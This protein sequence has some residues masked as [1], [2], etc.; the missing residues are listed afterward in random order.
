MTR[1]TT[2]TR[3]RTPRTN[4]GERVSRT[5]ES[6]AADR[7]ERVAALQ[8]QILTATAALVEAGAWQRMLAVA[9]RFHTYSLGNQLLIALQDPD[10]T[11]IAGPDH[12][13]ARRLERQRVDHLALRRPDRDDRSV[14]I[15]P[16]DAVGPPAGSSAPWPSPRTLLHRSHWRRACRRWPTA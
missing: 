5:P 7:A 14:G 11:R 13:L 6:R 4:T 3:R 10:A 9:A 15:D 2:T 1:S 12:R 16:V 8:E